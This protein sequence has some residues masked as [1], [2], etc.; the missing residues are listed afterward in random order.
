MT[1]VHIKESVDIGTT[2]LKPFELR[3]TLAKSTHCIQRVI[4]V[5]PTKLLNWRHTTLQ[6]KCSISSS[7]NFMGMTL[8]SVE[9][10]FFFLFN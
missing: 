6:V 5:F 4:I 2:E 1:R 7:V 8:M 9:E 3:H 10:K